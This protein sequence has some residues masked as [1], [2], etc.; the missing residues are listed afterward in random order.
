MG[1]IS[2]EFTPGP[3]TNILLQ[4]YIHRGSY[5]LVIEEINRGNAAAI[6]GDTFQLLD[7][8]L[9]GWSKY[10]VVNDNIKNYLTKIKDGNLV[11]D[12]LSPLDA[13]NILAIIDRDNGIRLPR[14]LSILATMN[15]SDQ[16][17]F[18][19]DNAFQRRFDMKLIKNEFPD[20]TI[21]DD[22]SLEIKKEKEL[23]QKQKDAVIQK[24]DLNWSTFQDE[25]NKKISE[26]SKNR[27]LSSMEDKRIGCWFVK[28]NGETPSKILGDVFANK[29]LKYL[30]DDAFKFDRDKV[31]VSKYDSLESLITGFEK[32]ENIF[33]NGVLPTLDAKQQQATH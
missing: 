2:Y 7:R 24:L 20:S 27:G 11:S 9:D 29:V 10:S 12:S 14:N 21:K 28:N 1:D 16:N 25:I 5:C 26:L 17:V 8:E 33:V 15:T 22:D 32:N 23:I 31:F 3:F 4:A 18:T 6:F 19:L 30:W 13:T